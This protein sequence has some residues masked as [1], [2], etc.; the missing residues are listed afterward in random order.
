MLTDANTKQIMGQAR[1][2]GVELADGTVLPADLVIMAV[3]I[4]PNAGLAKEAGLA[5]NRGIVVDATMA[6]SDPSI[7]ALGECVEAGGACFGL[8]APL[9]AMANVVAAQLAGDGSARF[10]AEA[11]PTRLK[12]TGINLYSAGDFAE[13]E[14]RDEIVLHD[15]AGGV[16]KRLILKDDIVIGTVLYGE[17]GDGPWYFDLMRA[18]ADVGALRD[19]L[20]FGQ[21]FQSDARPASKQSTIATD[22][23]PLDGI[24]E[25][26]Q[27]RAAAASLAAA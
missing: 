9:Y 27:V 6:T 12:V 13:A 5:V 8:V 16:Y 7:L 19:T 20:I 25:M 17:T 18:E 10:L 4:R 11:T 2:T 22:L 26:P 23:S 1:V 21:A 24:G 14:D 15:P 3:G